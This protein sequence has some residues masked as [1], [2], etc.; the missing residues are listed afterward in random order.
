MVGSHGLLSGTAIREYLTRHVVPAR[1]PAFL[2]CP[3]HLSII[4]P[5]GQD[6]HYPLPA[7]TIYPCY[8]LAIL[9]AR[10]K[11]GYR[12]SHAADWFDMFQKSFTLVLWPG[13]ICLCSFPYSSTF[14]S[15]RHLFCNMPRLY[16]FLVTS[17]YRFEPRTTRPLPALN[18]C[19]VSCQPWAGLC[20]DVR[21]HGQP[22]SLPSY[23]ART[24]YRRRESYPQKGRQIIFTSVFGAFLAA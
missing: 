23:L 24:L 21:Q 14:L 5:A 8:Q 11:C 17:M 22:V 15:T 19:P 4:E 13:G 9:L 16:A 6:W 7:D 18:Q 10:I 12:L 20:S 3:F 1:F 2:H